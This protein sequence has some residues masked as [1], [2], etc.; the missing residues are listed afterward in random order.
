MKCNDC[1][2][3]F[4]YKLKKDKKGH[5]ITKGIKCPNCGWS[6]SHYC[7]GGLTQDGDPRGFQYGFYIYY[8]QGTVYD[9]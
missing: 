6:S 4:Y 9:S 1:G 3:K 2:N 5:Y 8:N 7:S